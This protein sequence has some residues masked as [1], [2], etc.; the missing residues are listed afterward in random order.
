MTGP[1]TQMASPSEAIRQELETTH[2][3]LLEALEERG[4]AHKMSRM[5]ASE[6]FDHY[7]A[8]NGIHGW[9][10]GLFRVALK[11]QEIT[12]DRT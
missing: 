11:C 5:T 6:M 2:P 12:N 4:V 1:D 3:E 8:W 9:G 10:G 7:C